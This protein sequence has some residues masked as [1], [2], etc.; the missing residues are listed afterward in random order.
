MAAAY[1]KGR[2]KSPTPARAVGWWL[3]LLGIDFVLG[4][5]RE[6][7]AEIKPCL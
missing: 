6:R 3:H 5:R 7:G 2:V 4:L 1:P